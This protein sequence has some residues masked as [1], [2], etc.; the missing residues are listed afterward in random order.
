MVTVYTKPNC[1]QCTMTINVLEKQEIPYKTEN[2]LTD[3]NMDYVKQLGY[4]AAP[5][6]VTATEHWSGFR[7]ERIAAYV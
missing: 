3:E 5:V 7:P 2:I 4:L 6:V 1:V